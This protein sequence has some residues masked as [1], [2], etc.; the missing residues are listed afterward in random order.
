MKKILIFLVLQFM[1]NIFSFAQNNRIDS[2]GIILENIAQE[3]EKG[4]GMNKSKISNYNEQLRKFSVCSIPPKSIKRIDEN[5]AEPNEKFYY[6][7]NWI[8]LLVRGKEARS[9]A[10]KMYNEF[11]GL[12]NKGKGDLYISSHNLRSN[13]TG[14][15]KISTSGKQDVLVVAQPFGRVSVEYGDNIAG[16][17]TGVDVNKRKGYIKSLKHFQHDDEY[18]ITLHITN[19]TNNNIS[20][21]IILN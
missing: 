19:R 21:T 14:I 3:F 9:L 15:I 18:I 5:F 10:D 20:F 12:R 8:D 6:L 16:N 13:S 4:E 1:V 11:K 17:V 2:Y 7:P